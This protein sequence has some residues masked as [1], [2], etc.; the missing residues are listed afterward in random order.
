MMAAAL[1]PAQDALGQGP[2]PAGRRELV[3]I[4]RDSRGVGLEGAFVEVLGAATRTD[5]KG[6]FRLSTPDID[7]ATITIRLAGFGPL[8]ALISTRNRMWDTVMVELEQLSQL[9]SG[10]KIEEDRGRQ[11]E[12]LLGFEERVKQK[13]SGVFITRDD[14]VKRNT[15]RL[16]DVL[17]TRR[18]INL[19]RLAPGRYGA[20]FATYSGSRA[21]CIPDMWLDGQRVRGMEIDD[22]PANTVEGL[23]LYDSFATVP[24]QFS[25]TANAV[26]CGTIVAW[27]RPPGTRRP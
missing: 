25:H 27:T 17:Q 11:R 9:L 7:T 23:E 13:V 19:V 21:A 12:G 14:I 1:V 2:P 4:V 8:E 22:L 26:P 5:A 15:A 3:G 24:F 18:G 6:A 20:R 16:S 10:V